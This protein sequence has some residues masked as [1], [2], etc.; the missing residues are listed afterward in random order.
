MRKLRNS[1]PVNMLRSIIYH[2]RW[3]DARVRK[4]GIRLDCAALCAFLFRSE[5]AAA[6]SRPTAAGGGL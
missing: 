3:H 5:R 6:M 4:A 1:F 2:I